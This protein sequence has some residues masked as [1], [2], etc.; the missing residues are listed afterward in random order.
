MMR[1]DVDELSSVERKI[2][3]ELPPETVTD[4]FS[5]AYKDLGRRVRIKGFRSGKAP[6]R[7][8][9]GMYGDEIK[10]QVR[11]QLVESSL[12]EAIKERGLQIVS[13]PEID[14]NDLQEGQGFS[15]SAT[16]EVKPQLEF[17]NY[18]GLELERVRL[19]ITDEQVNAALE[20]LRESHASLEPVTDREIVEQ[21]DFVTLDFEGSIGGKPVPGAKSNNY[22]LEV[23]GGRA[24]PQFEEAISGL[25][26]GEPKT[27]QVTY[28]EDY[29]THELAGKTVDF[30]IT[31]RDIKRKV[32]PVLDDEFAKDHGECGS[33]DE[34]KGR[35]RMR[36]EEELKQIQDEEL[37]EQIVSRL[38]KDH[39]FAPPPAMVDRQTRYL[40]E[41]YQSQVRQSGG[42]SEQTPPMEEVRKNLEERARRQVQATLLVEKVAEKEK[43]DASDK[44]IQER[45]D[46]LAR[47]AGERAK[48]VRDFYSRED[49]RGELRAQIVFDRTLGFLLEKANVKEVDPPPLKV[50]DESKNR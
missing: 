47:G 10:G 13:R 46:R 30:S 35:I 28:P 3:I 32:L 45:V 40:M 5:R 16:V 41:R 19:A 9:E 22:V 1:I 17:E 21:G 15:F 43:I 44:D 34:L 23:G 18:L 4:E 20:R 49:A 29:A 38:I 48:N 11:S 26:V 42:Q 27:V 8:L 7:V 6:R 24:L 12:E 2:R 14:A 37:K 33:L 25:K 36:L 50:D 39:S 31:V